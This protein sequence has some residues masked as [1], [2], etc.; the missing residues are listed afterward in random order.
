MVQIECQKWLVDL[1]AVGIIH[2][3]AILCV[4]FLIPEVS[5]PCFKTW[6]STILSHGCTT[7]WSQK[8]A[9]SAQLSVQALWSMLDCPPPTVTL[10]SWCGGEG[11][12]CWAQQACFWVSQSSVGCR[13]L[14]L[15]ISVSSLCP[16]DCKCHCVEIISFL[17]QTKGVPIE[18]VS[19]VVR[20][21]WLWRRV[22]YPGGIIPPKK[23]AQV[24]GVPVDLPPD[25]KL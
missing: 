10:L 14:R 7:T 18:E 23:T 13:L 19:D 2:G 11:S 17:L 21:H 15:C 9:M 8:S 20:A 25:V 5:R 1:L 16:V 4:I 3:I 24:D 12:L 6:L 22:A